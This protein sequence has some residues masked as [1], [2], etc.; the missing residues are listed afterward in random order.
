MKLPSISFCIKHPKSALLKYLL[1]FAYCFPDKAYLKLLYKIQMRKK[2]NLVP[3]R[4]FSEKLQWLKL[5]DHNPLYTKMVDKVAAKEYVAGVL[6]DEFIIPTLGVWDNAEDIDWDELP[7]Q[8]VLKCNHDSGGLVICRDKSKLDKKSAI[9]RLNKSLKT[10]FYK[11]GREWPYKNVP[12]KI[13]AEKYIEPSSHS[14]DLP[15]YKF[16]CFNGEPKYCQVITG[17]NSVMCVD[18]FDMNWS[19]QP[20]HEPKCY[21]FAQIS[22]SK[23]INFEKMKSAA[24]AL[25]DGKPFSRIDFYEIGT[26][27]LFGEITFFPT[28][29][30]GGFEPYEWDE[31]FGEM[32]ILPTKI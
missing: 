11:E 28:S 3:P 10:N 5:Y 12:R 32:I 24:A 19:H 4:T 9:K 26:R 7:D 20:F 15:D 2:L 6:G 27:V 29:G 18:F 1:F 23:P 8:F 22:P 14:N 21:P 16:F 31:I 30:M 25:A 13:L 17:R